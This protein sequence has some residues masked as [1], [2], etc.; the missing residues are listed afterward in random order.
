LFNESRPD[1]FQQGFN[2]LLVKVDNN[3]ELPDPITGIS[4]MPGIAT[5]LKVKKLIKVKLSEPFNQC[6]D[7]LKTY[8]SFNSTLYE[9]IVSSNFTYRQKNCLD[10]A[11]GR[12]LSA[13]LSINNLFNFKYWLQV[14]HINTF[15]L[16]NQWS[17]YYSNNTFR[18]NLDM[19]PLECNSMTYEISASQS[20]YPSY[21]EYL[22][23]LNNSA[24]ISKFPN[25]NLTSINELKQSLYQIYI[26]FENL[27]YTKISEQPQNTIWNLI[28]NI[29]GLF[30]LFLGLSVL[31]FIDFFQIILQL[32]FII[33]E[34]NKIS[35]KID[36]CTTR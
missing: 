35:T 1:L 25:G 30:G 9:A 24:L 16:T 7:T 32:L 34:K 29:G 21:N 12:S 8:H 18:N 2:G 26:Y 14:N 4:I 11:F 20:D 3:S 36:A 19:C 33:L 6:I 13:N 28:S 23:L 17:N 15:Q 31:S 27:E 22:S 10:F 5:F